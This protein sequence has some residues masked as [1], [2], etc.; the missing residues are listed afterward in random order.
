[1]NKDNL[2][3]IVSI[4]ALGFILTL[5]FSNTGEF[6]AVKSQKPNYEL[7]S[8]V[9]PGVTIYNKPT[10]I[11]SSDNLKG[12]QLEDINPPFPDFT[13]P[14]NPF[15]TTDSDNDGITNCLDNCVTKY[16]PGQQDINGDGEG[17]MCDDTDG[18]GL[19][20]HFELLRGSHPSGIY[21][22]QLHCIDYLTYDSDND[23][24]SDGVEYGDYNGYYNNIRSTFTK[25]REKEVEEE[26]YNRNQVLANNNGANIPLIPGTID[27]YYLMRPYSNPCIVDTDQ[28]GLN[29]AY[30][31]NRGLLAWNPDSDQ[32]GL[33]DGY[34]YS[35][36][37]GE[38]SYGTDPLNSDTD[39]DNIPDGVEVAWE[40]MYQQNKFDPINSD[41]D[42]NG[43]TD[44]NEDH[45]NDG[46]TN[47]EEYNPY[48][49]DN[50]YMSNNIHEFNVYDAINLGYTAHADLCSPFS[51]DTDN[52]GI[53]DS[54][55]LKYALTKDR[56][57]K[58]NTM[59]HD[60]FVKSGIFSQPFKF[61]ARCNSAD[62]DGD[63]LTD[64]DEACYYENINGIRCDPNS[65]TVH[66]YPE[67]SFTTSG[68]IIA[69]IGTDT[70]PIYGD[71][72]W[73]SYY[74]SAQQKR[75][76]LDSDDKYPLDS[77]LC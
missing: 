76:C 34:S 44:G 29:D 58:P 19:T 48:P 16:N 22:H 64:S 15:D 24:L 33:V 37:Y 42:S 14:C 55:E 6:L 63:G 77:S 11:G 31:Y 28:D 71:S 10:T 13:E 65:T 61:R 57:Y 75:I 68:K 3:I 70:S 21:Q 1:M 12:G 60:L 59:D 25:V 38:L 27:D 26:L 67:Y 46:L 7:P 35:N 56:Y 40:L 36:R 20:D 18:D 74:S 66:D 4:L 8:D 51:K 32:D 50:S 17:D 23:G 2:P 39:G 43:I 54:T 69:N 45:D 53:S 72:D 9:N 41:T 52:D 30:E 49:N 62:S 73:D 5:S 47:S